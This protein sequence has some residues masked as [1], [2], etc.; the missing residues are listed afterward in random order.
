MTLTKDECRI[1]ANAL[2][3]AKYNFVNANDIDGLFDALCGLEKNLVVAGLDNRRR[4]RTSM[5]TWADVL[6]R[7]AIKNNKH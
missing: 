7:Y 5:D 6:K 3:E 1:L 2:D 4:G